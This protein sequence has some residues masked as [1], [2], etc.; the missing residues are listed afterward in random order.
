M[1][2]GILCNECYKPL[3]KKEASVYPLQWQYSGDMYCRKHEDREQFKTKRITEE[4]KKRHYE[5]YK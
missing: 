3:T 2:K 5:D 1:R 4:K